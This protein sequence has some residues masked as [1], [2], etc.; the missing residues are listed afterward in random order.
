LCGTIFPRRRLGVYV[1]SSEL[2]EMAKEAGG[3]RRKKSMFDFLGGEEVKVGAEGEEDAMKGKAS[4][5]RRISMLSAASRAS[6]LA[7]DDDDDE[8]DNMELWVGLPQLVKMVEKLLAA[9]VE[10][11][12]RDKIVVE[13]IEASDL[14]GVDR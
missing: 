4:S 6:E 3:L 2:F 13:V 14:P 11:A 1:N 12:A 7:D 10:A 9:V 8:D 5:K